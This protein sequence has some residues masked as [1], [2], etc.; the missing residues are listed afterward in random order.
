L[1]SSLNIAYDVVDNEKDAMMTK[2]VHMLADYYMNVD[3]EDADKNLIKDV[4]DENHIN[5]HYILTGSD[6]ILRIANTEHLENNKETYIGLALKYSLKDPIY[7]LEYLFGSSPM[8]WNIIRDH[9]V[10][11]PYY[12][13]GDHDRMHDDFNSY[14]ND[15]KYS[16][17][18]PY[19]NLSYV[20]WQTPAF[21]TLNLLAL[22]IEGCFL[23][24]IFNNPAFYMYLSIILLILIQM[25][26]KTK[27]IFLMYVP[28]LL[29]VG[30]IFFSTP[31]QD[32]RYLYANLLVCYLLIIVFIGLRKSFQEKI[33]N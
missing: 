29:N 26:V 17:T 20:N 33:H 3:M 10:G 30:I 24:T 27:E 32:Y 4:L 21:D 15:H 16:P 8:V 2:V 11:R 9:W 5:D 7:C 19:E 18:T 22:G 6:P 28:V 31:L 23:D 12:L 13:N 1:I 14:Y 25:V